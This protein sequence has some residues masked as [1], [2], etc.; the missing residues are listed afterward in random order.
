MPIYELLGVISVALA[1]IALIPELVTYARGETKP[2]AFS[3]IGWGLLGFIQYFGM[4]EAG[5]G[6]GG[7]L[8]LFIAI[9]FNLIGFSAFWYGEKNITKSDTV[10]FGLVICSA[11]TLLIINN[12]LYALIIASLGDGFSF[13][14]TVRKSWHKP[15]TENIYT[16]YIY[17]M[18]IGFSLFAVED[19]NLA[20]VISQSSLLILYLS[21][22][23]ILLWRRK[24]LRTP[25]A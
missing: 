9:I 22:I 24:Q 1:F 21:F 16:F 10:A 18:S 3:W 6:A 5:S 11:L 23:V 25:L 7:Y 2:H 12:P 13:Y 14:P 4:T 20:S 19:F 8:F 15:W 17:L